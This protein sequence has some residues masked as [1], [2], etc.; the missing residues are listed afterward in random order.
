[1]SKQRTA[2]KRDL[3]VAEMT[4]WLRQQDERL[5]GCDDHF[6]AACR[7]IQFYERRIDS[8]KILR[9]LELEQK[10]LIGHRVNEAKRDLDKYMKQKKKTV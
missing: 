6:D 9:G 8:L 5:I 1:M 4:V 7:E 3:Y 10:A 2:P